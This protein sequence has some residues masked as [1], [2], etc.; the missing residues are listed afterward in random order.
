MRFNAIKSKKIQ[1]LIVAF[2][3]L[4]V[5]FEVLPLAHAATFMTHAE[6]ME[7][8]M[9]SSGTSAVAIAF[10]AGASDA[11]GSLTVNFGSWGGSVLSGAQTITTT[12]CTALTGAT[13]ALPSGTSLSANGA[14]NVITIGN[15][16]ALT[17]GTSYCAILSSVN[18][19]TNPATTGVYT[20]TLT[21]A[22]D[23]ATPV[24]DVIT[25]DQVV[26]SAT[27]PAT[28][29]MTYSGNTDA[30]GNL[31]ASN[32]TSTPGVTTTIA[33][34]AAYGWFMWA[35]DTNAGLRSTI[36]S[37]TIATVTPGTNTNMS[38]RNGTEAYA[39]GV[40]ATGGTANANFI[41]STGYSGGG[42][43]NSSYNQIASGT[44]ATSGATVVTKEIADISATTPPANDYTDTISLVGAGSF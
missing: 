10:T 25:N 5:N 37:K 21:D 26:V 33:T 35:E 8:N 24:I 40:T 15:V 34:N 7:Y 18:A 29:T 43:S 42:L 6:V 20:V 9:D 39:L 3:L 36:Q 28:F 2:A 27:V 30:F 22:T 14:S 19:V 38:A 41:N 12:G 13:T 11:A 1:V 44:A 4:A 31:S 16:S 23:S 17:S 32:Y